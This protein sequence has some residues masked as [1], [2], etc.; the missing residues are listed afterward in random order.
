MS[1]YVSFTLPTRHNTKVDMIYFVYT[2][3][4]MIYGIIKNRTVTKNEE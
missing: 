3:Y 1:S 4:I 2:V